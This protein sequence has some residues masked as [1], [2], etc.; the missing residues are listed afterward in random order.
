MRLNLG[1]DLIL[2]VV[3][4]AGPVL[5]ASIPASEQGTT[6]ST[7]VIDASKAP[8]PPEPLPFVVGGRSPDG[9]V[10][11]ANSRYLV[12]DGTAWFPVMGE[13]HF[14]RYP[15]A[16][17]EEEILKM[18]AG[19]VQIISTYI[20]WIHHEE[21]EGQ[22]D[23]SRQRNL[24]R[25][26]ELCA[27]HGLYVWIRVGPWAHGEVRNGGLPDWLLRDHATRQNDPAYLCYVRR[28]TTIR[29]DENVGDDLHSKHPDIDAQY[30]SYP[31]LTAEMG[32]GMELSYHRRP[33]MSADDTAAMALVKLGSG[34][35]LYGYYMFHGGT[36][37]EG[38]TTTLQESQ[39]SGYPNDLPVRSY[40]YQA[41]LG[42]FGQMNSSFRELKGIHMFLHDF[43]SSLAPMAPYFPEHLPENRLDTKTPRVT[44]RIENNR[45][46]VFINNYQRNYP[47]PER[48]N[49]QIRL[50]WGRAP[51]KCRTIPWIFRAAR[52]QC[53]PSI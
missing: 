28:F 51:S 20:F 19:G 43:G 5:A 41:P 30:A 39:A 37:P 11:S 32:G 17:W 23:W 4:A 24:R 38:K 53:G 49:F 14:S 12:L 33:L 16:Y 2:A 46:Y 47:L 18:K 13:F 8:A 31:F 44:A 9:H 22:F 6:S 27:K 10:L 25:F 45:G 40:D 21:L 29:C 42:E 34:V 48:K 1:I 36:N 50:N 3:T 15:E 26:V 7:V 35:T 52:T